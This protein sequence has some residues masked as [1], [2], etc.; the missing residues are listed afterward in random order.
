M[1]VSLLTPEP[2][3]EHLAGLTF[4]TAEQTTATTPV[5]APSDPAWK[6]RDMWLSAGVVL[7]VV[8][9]WAYFTG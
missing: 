8:L 2:S 3:A 7:C 1:A 9:V 5:L 4:A 6:R